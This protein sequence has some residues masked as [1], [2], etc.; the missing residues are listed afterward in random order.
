[1][2]KSAAAFFPLFSIL[3]DSSKTCNGHKRIIQ[4][5]ENHEEIEIYYL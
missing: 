3:L 2:V 5:P 1:M 4:G